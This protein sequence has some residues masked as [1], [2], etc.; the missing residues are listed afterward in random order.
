MAKIQEVPTA[1]LGTDT[2]PLEKVEKVDSN[3]ISDSPSMFVNV[4]Q[5]NQNAKE[6]DYERVALANL[7]AN[8]TLDTK[9]N[10]NSLKQLKKANTS[11]TQELKECKS[12]L[13]VTNRTLGE[14]NSTRDSCLIALQNKEIKLEKYKTYLNRTN[15]YDTLERKFQ[16]V[17]AQKENNI[18][19]GLKVK[20][21][22][23]S[24]VKKEHNELVKHSLLIKSRYKGLV[25]E[26]N[27][28]IKDLKHKEEN[29]ID[30]MITMEK[31][32]KPT[33][34]NPMYLK[35]APSEK[36]CL[37]EI[38]Y[39]TSD[40]ANKFSPDME[41]T[42]TLKQASRSKLNKDIVMLYEKTSKAWKWRIAQKCPSRYKWVPKTKMKSVPKVRK[43]DIVQL[44]LFIVDFGRTKHMT[45]NL[46]LLCNFVEKFLG[47]VHFGNDQFTL[48]LGYGDLV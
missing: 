27:K 21:Y 10:K 38:P 39:D 36:P 28:V 3:V 33:L 17:L 8:L 16:T 44:I 34:A 7:I 48:I 30:K 15:E 1:D 22:E 31:Q 19:E 23:I 4:I 18:K 24:V 37:Y 12:T 20:A 35:K 29:D 25:K 43:E 41:D 5:T 46:K 40:P 42:L 32:L 9:E 13:G 47:T 2:K 45:G 6:C 14:S 11:L 26:K